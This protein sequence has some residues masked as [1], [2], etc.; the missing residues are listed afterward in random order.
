M[1]EIK[2]YSEI[3]KG[4]RYVSFDVNTN[5]KIYISNSELTKFPS[6][7]ILLRGTLEEILY[8]IDEKE[9]DCC[10]KVK[11]LIY[12]K[13]K[14]VAY[15]INFYKDYK[16]LKKLFSRDFVL[17]KYDCLNIVKVFNKLSENNIQVCDYNISNVLLNQ[18]GNVLICD[19]DGLKINNDD[20]VSTLNNRCLFVIVLAYLY[21]L[22][23]N[24]VLALLKN[25]DEFLIE[26]NRYLLNLFT[27][28]NLGEQINITEV[29]DLISERDVKVR[30]KYLKRSVSNLKN[31]P[32]FK[33]YFGY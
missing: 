19:L 11:S 9:I 17:K 24:E 6:R 31:N 4:I 23:T 7:R 29:V 22:P 28:I 21:K 32:Y 25:V 30:R 14:L 3:K 12:K 16:S 2:Q 15:K 26:N 10:V 27:R 18:K 8:Y 33:G 20:N 1:L 13:G 5:S